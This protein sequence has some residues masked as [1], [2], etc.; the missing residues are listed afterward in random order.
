MDCYIY[1]AYLRSDIISYIVI[2]ATDSK[3]LSAI[4]YWET[5][6]GEKCESQISLRLTPPPHTQ[7]FLIGWWDEKNIYFN[8]ETKSGVT[9]NQKKRKV[10]SATER[11]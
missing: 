1:T 11:Y 10:K 4:L 5:L 6:E 3:T 9:D 2:Y 7:Y 8:G